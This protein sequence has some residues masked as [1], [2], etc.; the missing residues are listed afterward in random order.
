VI[1]PANLSKLGNIDYCGR[2]PFATASVELRQTLSGSWPLSVFAG[3]GRAELRRGAEG[4]QSYAEEQ[5]TRRS[6]DGAGL[7]GS[8][9]SRGSSET[10]SHGEQD[11]LRPK[12]TAW[13]LPSSSTDPPAMRRASEV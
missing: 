9:R 11:T 13:M 6:G 10:S 5:R 3:G 8:G 12:S 1:T 2:R 7:R 4:E